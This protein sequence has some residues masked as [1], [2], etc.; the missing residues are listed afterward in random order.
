M[1]E[2]ASTDVIV[3]EGSVITPRLL[4]STLPLLAPHESALNVVASAM[5]RTMERQ[6]VSRDGLSEAHRQFV[7]MASRCTH[8]ITVIALALC[9]HYGLAAPTAQQ[10][11]LVRKLVRKALLG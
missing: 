2:N 11:E 3:E 5:P 10:L 7:Y 4:S 9:R 8:D 6:N 1:S